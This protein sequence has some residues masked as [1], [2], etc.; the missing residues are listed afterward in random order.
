MKVILFCGGQGQRLLENDPDRR[1]PPRRV[2]DAPK[3]LHLVGGRP[4][5]WHLMTW[6]ATHGHCDFILC[7]GFRA[8]FVRAWVHQ[9]ADRRV[10]EPTARPGVITHHFLDGEAAG[11]RVTVLDSGLDAPVGQRLKAARNLVG[12]DELF[13]ANYADGLSDVPLP[14]M[15]DQARRTGAVATMLAVPPPSSLHSVRM[16]PG[17]CQVDEIGPLADEQVL[18]NG[19]FFVM[20]P[21]VFAVL[22]DGEDLVDAPFRRLARAGGLH[23]YPYTGFWRCMDTVKD[24]QVLDQLW[25]SGARPWAIWEQNTASAPLRRP[26]P[27]RV[28]SQRRARGD[29]DSNGTPVSSRR[30]NRPLASAP[31]AL[32]ARDT[33]HPTPTPSRTAD[34]KTG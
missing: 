30:E 14:A 2:T 12:E 31:A 20:R 28:G 27:R 17:T 29:S 22:Q 10:D 32:P 26:H 19:G 11:W 4:I 18:V 8:E 25:L 5:L 23:A 21:E 13:L 15:I 3:P 1:F 7:V 9:L 33:R 16:R 34:D 24:K 6:Y